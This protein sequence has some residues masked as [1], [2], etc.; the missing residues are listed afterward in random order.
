MVDGEINYNFHSPSNKI[1][2]IC[3]FNNIILVYNEEDIITFE[4]NGN[5]YQLNDQ[6]D[7]FIELKDSFFIEYFYFKDWNFLFLCLLIT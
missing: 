7:K 6:D 1:C 3:A 5:T 4:K 2:K